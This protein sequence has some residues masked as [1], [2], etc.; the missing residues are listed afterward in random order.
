MLVNKSANVIPFCP[1]INTE[2]ITLQLLERDRDKVSDEFELFYL[3]LAHFIN[4]V[5][6]IKTN[7]VLHYLKSNRI[8]VFVCQHVSVA[9]LHFRPS[10]IVFTPHASVGDSFIS[11]PHAPAYV[12]RTLI[13]EPK[14]FLFSFLGSLE[15]HWTR[16]ILVER[17]PTCWD[18]KQQWGLTKGLGEQFHSDYL[19][20]IGRSE[21]SLCPRGT[22]ISSVRLFESMAMDSFPVIIAD[23]YKC[24]L[25]SHINWNRISVT[26]KESDVHDIGNNLNLSHLNRE[27]LREVYASYLST[28]HLHTAALTF[29]STP[30]STQTHNS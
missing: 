14:D 22:G 30:S 1:Y 23:G 8:R 17:Y 6:L 20:L 3:P 12:N 28:E 18:S 26:V 29:L 11:I 5:G 4:T 7:S 24:P 25:D 13:R 2:E 15:T 10:D 16:K 19:S 27:Y 21:F 9:N